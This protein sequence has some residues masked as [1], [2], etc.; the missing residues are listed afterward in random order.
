ME[1]LVEQL[2]EAL[3]YKPRGDGVDFHWKC[4]SLVYFDK[5]KDIHIK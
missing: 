2:D 1:F 3:C 5:R 4:G